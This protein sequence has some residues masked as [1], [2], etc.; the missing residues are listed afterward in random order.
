[1][2]GHPRIPSPEPR[3]PVDVR[4]EMPS[5]RRDEQRVACRAQL[6]PAVARERR[7]DTVDERREP[8][9]CL[10]D[11]ELGCRRDGSVHVSSAAAERVGKRQQNAADLLR[12]L[13]F[14]RDD[15][16]VD[17]DRAERFEKQA[18]AAPRAAVDDS[19]YC[20]A[21]LA[22]DDEDVPAVA[23]GHDLLLEILGRVATAQVRFERSTQPRPLFTQAI[24]QCRELRAGVIEDFER[25]A[26]L[27]ADV[28]DLMLERG[29]RLDD[30]AEQWKTPTNL[31]NG[32]ASRVDRRQKRGEVDERLRLEDAA[33]D[34]QRHQKGI[35]VLR[36]LQSDRPVAQETG[37][38]VRRCEGRRDGAAVGQRL[39]LRQ[40]RRAR[41]RQ[42]K[43]AY[44]LDDPIVF[45]RPQGTG[46]HEISEILVSVRLDRAI[47]EY[48]ASAASGF[49]GSG[50]GVQGSEQPS[51]PERR[52]CFRT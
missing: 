2:I 15:V 40:T 29:G 50:L 12:L 41:R 45:E 21:M 20:R 26:D 7:L 24:A 37:R 23:V 49:K 31:A 44:R 51:S 39:Q 46:V 32:S 48:S 4:S 52:T 47:A 42:C 38:L 22:A 14:E 27:A 1:M 43:A 36:R 16:V 11:V 19:R 28:G 13:L 25:R 30:R 10:Q 33:F 6:E 35:E 17:L 8:R 9:A 34:R 3:I 5:D 18:G